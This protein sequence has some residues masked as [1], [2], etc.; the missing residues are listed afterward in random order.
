MAI[1]TVEELIEA[2]KARV[3]EDNSDETIALLEDIS[4]TFT[5][6]HDET[7]WKKKFEENDAEWRQKY[8]D[9]F[10]KK[11]DDEDED[12]DHPQEQER[13]STDY[14]SLFTMKE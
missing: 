2:V 14:D 10:S 3:G 4:D 9:R 7:D 8:K 13:K 12:I 1:K 6:Q 5:A 11:P